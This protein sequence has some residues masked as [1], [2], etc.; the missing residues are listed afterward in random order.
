MRL[1]HVQCTA[2]GFRAATAR[3]GWMVDLVAG[4]MG[5]GAIVV[6]STVVSR[7]RWRCRFAR[8]ARSHPVEIGAGKSY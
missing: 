6:T 2:C 5:H 8:P 4:H 3:T 1:L 7:R